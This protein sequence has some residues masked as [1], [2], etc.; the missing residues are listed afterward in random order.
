MPASVLLL[1]HIY[2]Y[3]YIFVSPSLSYV[4]GFFQNMYVFCRCPYYLT[5]E[6]HKDVDILFAPYNYLI[7]N[8]YR[9]YLKVNWN[10]SILIFDEAHNLVSQI[11]FCVHLQLSFL[12]L[13]SIFFQFLKHSA[14]CKICAGKFMRRLSFI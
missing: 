6:V 14:I 3:I 10:S 12:F 8:A 7:S 4:S 5:R 1:Q 13:L 2:I 11:F 9:K